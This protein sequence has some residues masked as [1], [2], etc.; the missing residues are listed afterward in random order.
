MLS[1]TGQLVDFNR[2]VAQIMLSNKK[3]W[4]ARYI[5]NGLKESDKLKMIS[6]QPYSYT[7]YLKYIMYD[8]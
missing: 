2:D 3:T 8:I 6:S 7:T 5:L 1:L 4:E